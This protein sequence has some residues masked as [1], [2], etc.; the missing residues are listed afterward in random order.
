MKT[1][2]SEGD[3]SKDLDMLLRQQNN[4]KIDYVNGEKRPTKE[5]KTVQRKK[6]LD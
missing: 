6:M 5:K 1:D 2:F 4:V 3:S